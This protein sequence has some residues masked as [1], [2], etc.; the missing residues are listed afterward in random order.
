MYNSA[1]ALIIRIENTFRDEFGLRHRLEINSEE[2]SES[3]EFKFFFLNFQYIASS[4]YEIN[5]TKNEFYWII[6]QIKLN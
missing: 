6:M 4:S 1:A 2:S 5:T 3:R